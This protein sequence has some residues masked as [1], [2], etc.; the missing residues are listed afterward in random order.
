MRPITADYHVHSTYSDGYF[1]PVMAK[2]A[3][4]F[5]LDGVG[6]ADHCIISEREEAR[7][8]RAVQG[9][10]LDQT[11][12]RR[13]TAIE[14]LRKT[15]DIDIYDAVELDYAPEDEDA[16]GEFLSS[17]DFDYTLGSVHRINERN[18]QNESLFSSLTD[19]ECADVVDTYVDRFVSLV[20]SGHFDIAAHPDLFE[21]NQHLRGYATTANYE[22]IARS[23]ES[24]DTIAEINAGR[25][26]TAYGKF[27]PNSE[28]L[29]V[30]LDHDIDMSIG[31][32]SHHPDAFDNRLPKLNA[33]LERR[34]VTPTSPLQRRQ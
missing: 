25:V 24:S 11:H 6:F 7:T 16:I 34:N 21:R 29:T 18:L 30:L 12:Q 1:L 15:I 31:T 2:R 14:H 3:Q 5:G 26:D 22:R 28:L 32:D 17:T 23:F 33:L 19:S 4:E 13:S 27:H 10:T 8:S 9:F 20:R